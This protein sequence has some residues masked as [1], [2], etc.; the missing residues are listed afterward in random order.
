MIQLYKKVKVHPFVSVINHKEAEEEKEEKD[1]EEEEDTSCC[2]ICDMKFKKDAVS[3]LRYL[4]NDPVF[5]Y[6]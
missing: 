2:K 5:I 3:M 6:V 1:D 4:L